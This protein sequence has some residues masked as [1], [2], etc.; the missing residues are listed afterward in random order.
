MAYAICQKLVLQAISK[1]VEKILC[2]TVVSCCA[3]TYDFGME[4]RFVF[5]LKNKEIFG[6]TLEVSFDQGLTGNIHDTIRAQIKKILQKAIQD[7]PRADRI[8]RERLWG[9][10]EAA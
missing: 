5:V 6:H 10:K 2:N 1:Q 7:L 4:E 8:E 3:N 9:I